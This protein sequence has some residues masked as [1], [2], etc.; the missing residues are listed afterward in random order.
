MQ[1]FLSPPSRFCG[2]RAAATATVVASTARGVQHS[3]ESQQCAVPGLLETITI[4]PQRH[5]RSLR[6]VQWS[7]PCV[8]INRSR[9]CNRPRFRSSLIGCSLPWSMR[10][11]YANVLIDRYYVFLSL[12]LSLSWVLVSSAVSLR[13]QPRTSCTSAPTRTLVLAEPLSRRTAA[14]ASRGHV[15]THSCTH[16]ATGHN[17]RPPSDPHVSHESRLRCKCC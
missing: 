14:T 3:G 12:S 16:V 4:V 9:R 8:K 13:L 2:N 5:H 1:I 17:R 6:S 10:E 11:P 7:R 15:S